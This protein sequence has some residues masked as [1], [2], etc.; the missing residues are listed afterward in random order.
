MNLGLKLKE[1]SAVFHTT[2]S[3]EHEKRLVEKQHKS[4]KVDTNGQLTA[5]QIQCLKSFTG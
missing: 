2:C 3:A 5:K 4:S 1:F